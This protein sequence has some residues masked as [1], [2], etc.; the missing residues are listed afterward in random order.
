MLDANNT[1]SLESHDFCAAIRKLV[2]TLPPESPP[3]QLSPVAVVLSLPLHGA[4]LPTQDRG[5]ARRGTRNALPFAPVP[6]QALT[7]AACG[8]PLAGSAVVGVLP[9]CLAQD[10]FDSDLLSQVY[11]VTTPARIPTS[12]VR[13]L[14]GGPQGFEPKIHMT[15]S[16]FTSITGNGALCGADSRL[17]REGF[18][19]LMREQVRCPPFSAAAAD[20]L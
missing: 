18:E 2:C 11:P 8:G 15:D 12:I 4:A 9:T 5:L 17:G 6:P 7:V 14:C 3:P 20:R 1:G 13:R 16:D 19:V 10:G